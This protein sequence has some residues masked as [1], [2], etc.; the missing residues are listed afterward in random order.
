MK[1]I[2]IYLILWQVGDV[3]DQELVFVE[4]LPSV[5]C[6]DPEIIVL[7]HTVDMVIRGDL[8]I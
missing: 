6:D 4:L 7:L 8:S 2:A 5:L 1:H 3:V